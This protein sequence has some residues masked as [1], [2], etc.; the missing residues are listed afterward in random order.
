[1]NFLAHVALASDTADAWGCSEAEAEGLVAGAIIGDFVKGYIPEDWPDELRIGVALHRKI[2]A[3]SNLHPA[4]NRTSARFPDEL[5]RYA[6]IFLDLLADHSLARNWDQYYENEIGTYAASCYLAI[7]R[8]RNQ[9]PERGHRFVEYMMDV[10][11]L[12]QYHDWGHVTDGLAS[13]L[14]RLSKSPEKS[15]VLAA[16]GALTKA[17][18]EM[19]L[20][21]YPDLRQE[22]SKWDGSTVGR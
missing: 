9:L 16:C 11:L 4:V 1:M 2:D 17:S 22:L 14:R 20:E 19:L 10:D 3:L 13:V 18:D 5:R 21:L 8:F 7:E 12:S 15:I 6:P